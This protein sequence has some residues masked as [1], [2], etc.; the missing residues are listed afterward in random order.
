MVSPPLRASQRCPLAAQCPLC[1]HS[2]RTARYYYYWHLRKQVLHSQ[3]VLREE[4]Y[5][6]LTAFALQA[7]LGDFKRNKHYGKYFE[8]E[9]YFPA[10]VRYPG[11]V[12]AL[13]LVLGCSE[14]SGASQL[15]LVIK[16][17]GLLWGWE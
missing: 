1:P 6:L 5:F 9:A 12:P 13:R 2:D 7:D 14:H 16:T 4:A 11:V 15:I 3:C 10:W 8:P 17:T